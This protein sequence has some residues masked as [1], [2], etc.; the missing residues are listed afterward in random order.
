MHEPSRS[1]GVCVKHGAKIK[2]CSIEGCTKSSSE[3]WVS[4]RHGAKLAKKKYTKVLFL[5]P[6]V[7]AVS[8]AACIAKTAQD[9]HLI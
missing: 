6:R 2:R 8:C 7:R 1:R 9:R 5:Y 3:K 4:V